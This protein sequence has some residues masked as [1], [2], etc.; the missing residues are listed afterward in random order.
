MTMVPLIAGMGDP[1]F[2]WYTPG[3]QRSE[4]DTVN[5]AVGELD[6]DIMAST[7]APP[8]FK[9][10]WRAFVADWAQ[11]YSSQGGVTGWLSRFMTAGGHDQTE[12]YRRQLE[13]W[14]AKYLTYG[15]TTSSPGLPPVPTDSG[16]VSQTFKWVAITAVA[17]GSVYLVSKLS[18]LLPAPRT[19]P[20]RRRRR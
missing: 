3:D 1:L 11:F 8:D 9:T 15:G 6:A 20:R 14:R 18:V 13:T 19:N 4:E 10:Q 7:A 2:R 16:G 17:L 5:A 12:D